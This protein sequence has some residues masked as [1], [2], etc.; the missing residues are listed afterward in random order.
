[1]EREPAWKNTPAGRTLLEQF[2]D[3]TKVEETRLRNLTQKNLAMELN[4]IETKFLKRLGSKKKKETVS[5]Q[6]TA[7][8]N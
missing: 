7:A 8:V 6:K 3:M 5:E 2:S 4:Q 1:M